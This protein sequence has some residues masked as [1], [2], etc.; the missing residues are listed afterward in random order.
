MT[1]TKDTVG[2]ARLDLLPYTGLKAIANVRLFGMQK[3]PGDRHNYLNTASEHF[4]AAAL[5]HIYANL[6][7]Q[8]LDSESGHPHLAHAALSLLFALEIDTRNQE[9]P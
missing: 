9:G 7:G 4:K 6:E 8:T 1:T 3:Y 2:K 5:R